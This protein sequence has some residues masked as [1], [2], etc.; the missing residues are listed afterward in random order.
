MEFSIVKKTLPDYKYIF[1]GKS[2]DEINR[3]SDNPRRLS[4]RIRGLHGE[5][6][7]TIAAKMQV[8]IFNEFDS[9]FKYSQITPS[10]IT[11]VSVQ[12]TTGGRGLANIMLSKSMWHEIFYDEARSAWY[13]IHNARERQTK[14]AA[15][16]RKIIRDKC[17]YYRAKAKAEA[18][19]PSHKVSKYSNVLITIYTDSS[20]K[21][22]AR[23]PGLVRP[24][25]NVS[26]PKYLRKQSRQYIA[27]NVAVAH[28]FYRATGKIER[29]L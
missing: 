19:K 3:F 2:E 8:A 27:E 15:A 14:R 21:L 18:P 22:R 17:R 11:V 9:K 12:Q 4:V 10:D 1:S 26:F 13:K 29:V 6:V 28:G 20:G 25:W 7:E 5:G 23:A 16:R 24:F